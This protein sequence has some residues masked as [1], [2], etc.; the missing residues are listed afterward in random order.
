MKTV[1]SQNGTS[2]EPS[3]NLGKLS[4]AKNLVFRGGGSKGI[5]YVGALQSLSEQG[6]LENIENVAGSSAG[7]MTAAIVACGGSADLMEYF[8]SANSLADFVDN[9]LTKKLL[10]KSEK[11]L[12]ADSSVDY[13]SI[14]HEQKG[15]QLDTESSLAEAKLV[16]KPSKLTFAIAS[17]SAKLVEAMEHVMRMAIFTHFPESL[18]NELNNVHEKLKAIED[19]GSA[20][21]INFAKRQQVLEDTQK[22]INEL[23]DPNFDLTFGHLHT[24]HQYDPQRFKELYVT[25][26]DENGELRIFSHEQDADMPV[27]IA[28]RV[29]AS[30]PGVFDPVIYEG[31]KYIDGGAANNLPVN[32]FFNKEEAYTPGVVTTIGVS[33]ENKLDITEKE[34]KNP[35]FMERIM[36]YLGDFVKKMLCK[37]DVE[38]AVKE[39]KREMLKYIDN[40]NLF[41]MVAPPISITTAQMHIDKE[42]KEGV[43][44]VGKAF[45]DMQLK[46]MIDADYRPQPFDEKTAK[47]LASCGE[48][49]EQSI[50]KTIDFKSRLQNFKQADRPWS[51]HVEKT[52]DRLMLVKGEATQDQID[53]C[54]QW[55]EIKS[56]H[57]NP[58]DRLREFAYA[59]LASPLAEPVSNQ[60]EINFS[61]ET[62]K[63]INLL[64]NLP[65]LY[66]T[67]PDFTEEFNNQ[68]MPSLQRA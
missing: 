43:I 66:E 4:T 13:S 45:C 64:K 9:R 29:S 1:N 19:K 33:C 2:A 10:P 24:L 38:G 58:A 16:T 68:R 46:S 65:G 48:Q 49:Q 40:G 32:I 21:Y 6:V 30:L 26:T 50:Q 56:V 63:E 67:T 28:V 11:S 54:L 61:K 25:G 35:S 5:A 22:I 7:A 18:D 55:Q 14:S 62:R 52:I 53:L 42:E 8:C 47:I 36:G 15:S 17:K 27:S 57:S 41:V 60:Q 20:E 59:F 31:R 39:Q 3:V 37:L 12:Q 51:Q 23:H 34:F 44:K